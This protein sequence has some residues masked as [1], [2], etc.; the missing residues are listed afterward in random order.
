MEAQIKKNCVEFF[1]EAKRVVHG[2][3]VWLCQLALKC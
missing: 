3:K 1:G 2:F